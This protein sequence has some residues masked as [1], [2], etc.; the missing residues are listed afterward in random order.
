MRPVYTDWTASAPGL[1]SPA[2]MNAAHNAYRWDRAAGRWL[3]RDVGAAGE[4][5]SALETAHRDAAASVEGIT[6]L[7]PA[8]LA[9][10]TYAG[11]CRR[12]ALLVESDVK[13][14]GEAGCSAA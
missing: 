6:G 5:L 3:L 14:A 2:Q 9:V 4:L 10:R 7:D 13:R 11:A 1:P 12:V 8:V